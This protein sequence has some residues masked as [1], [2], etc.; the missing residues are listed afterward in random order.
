MYVGGFAFLTLEGRVVSL[1]TVDNLHW[2]AA[3][4]GGCPVHY[5]TFSSIAGLN[6]LGASS[7]C[8]QSKCQSKIFQT[9]PSVQW[10]WKCPR[11]TGLG[12]LLIPLAAH[13]THMEG[14]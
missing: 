8:Q 2:I 9:L 5:R 7:S 14:F 10:G 11:T 12:Q 3:N 13:Q 4:C 1:S 6:S